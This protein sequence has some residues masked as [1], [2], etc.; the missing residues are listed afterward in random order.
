MRRVFRKEACRHKA[1][2][3]QHKNAFFHL[4]FV[5]SNTL[6]PFAGPSSMK[7]MAVGAA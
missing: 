2:Y 3:E 4:F 7:M 1:H 6:F 5:R